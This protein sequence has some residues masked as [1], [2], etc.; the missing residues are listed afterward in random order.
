[1]KLIN[2]LR[3][4]I[5]LVIVLQACT[6]SDVS[7]NQSANFSNEYILEHK[8]KYSIEIPDVYEL[9]HVIMAIKYQ[10]SSDD[11]F[12]EKNTSYFEEVISKFSENKNS[13]I[14]KSFNYYETDFK[15]NY[16][17]RTNSYNYLLDHNSIVSKNI[18]P[19]LWSPDIFKSLK[20]DI[21]DFAIESDFHNFYMD[22]LD[23]YQSQIALYDS[24]TPIK[25]IWQWLEGQFSTRYDCYKIIISPLTKGSHNTKRFETS[26]YKETIMFVSGLNREIDSFDTTNIILNIR[27]VFTEIDHNYVNP[28]SDRYKKAIS[29]AMSNLNVW[30]KENAINKLYDDAYSVFNEYMTWAVFDIYVSEKYP[31][32]IFENIRQIT[33]DKMEKGRGFIKFEEFENYLIGLFKNR[34]DNKTIEDLYPEVLQWIKDNN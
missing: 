11:Y 12:I 25:D 13:N 29:N 27:Y 2:I 3:T 34:T 18:Y 6:K 31:E 4:I 7:L 9:A 19:R 22:H 14:F 28:V 20:D 1:M 10:N 21:E 8:G 26:G 5:F 30:K 17:F 24:V 23:F 16:S 33:I 15:N 32:H